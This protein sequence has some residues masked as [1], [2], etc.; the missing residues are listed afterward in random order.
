MID[1]P[2]AEAYVRDDIE[3]APGTHRDGELIDDDRWR[4]ESDAMGQ[5]V[6]RPSV[7]GERRRSV[8][9]STSPSRRPLPLA[10]CRAYGYVKKAAA[11][12]NAR[13]ARLAPTWRVHHRRRRRGDRRAARRRV[14]T[15]R[16][17]ERLGTQTN[18]NVTR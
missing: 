12:V 13:R 1:D 16:D 6:S 4:V 11:M 9:S 17:T 5:C 14:P 3:L 10:V 8:R 2:R 18:M 7:S 15:L